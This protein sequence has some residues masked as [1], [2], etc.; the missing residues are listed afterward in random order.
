MVRK[1]L[2]PSALLAFGL[3]CAQSEGGFHAGVGDEPEIKGQPAMLASATELV[4]DDV[5]IA[6]ARSLD[7]V[8]ENHGDADLEVFEVVLT[9][10]PDYAFY[11]DDQAADGLVV[12]PGAD[13]TITVGCSMKVDGFTQGVLRIDSNDGTKPIFDVTLLASTEGWEDTGL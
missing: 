8:L 9:E 12:V 5:P 4:F 1:L 2:G 13:A 10:N 11:I 6:S 7:L 3:A